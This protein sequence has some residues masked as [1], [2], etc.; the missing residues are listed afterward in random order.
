M[1]SLFLN[2]PPLPSILT[3]PDEQKVVSDE[4]KGFAPV[5]AAAKGNVAEATRLMVDLYTPTRATSRDA[6]KHQDRCF[7]IMRE[8]SRRTSAHHLPRA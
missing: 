5:V 1:R 8:H 3:N 2:E 4:G 6:P 7:W